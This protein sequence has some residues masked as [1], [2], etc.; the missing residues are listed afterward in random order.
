MKTF[1][2][3]LAAL[4]FTSAFVIN[5]CGKKDET[6]Q[7]K[8]DTVQTQTKKQEQTSTAP[9]IGKI[10]NSIQKKNDELKN[11][12]ETNKLKEVHEYAF[13]VRDLIKTLPDQSA[14]L[15]ADKVDMLKMH[16]KEVEKTA[17]LL[18]KYGDNNDMKNTKAAYET[19][20]NHIQAIKAMYPAE[21][22]N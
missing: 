12:I 18:D 2:L 19:F 13:A 20:N 16:I 9:K 8:K 11:I 3:T 7:I 17:D 22:F 15:G 4:A 14:G 5:G 6:T 1:I 10:W 21:S